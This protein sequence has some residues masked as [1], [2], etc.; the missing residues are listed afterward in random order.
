M[1]KTSLGAPR[2][3]LLRLVRAACADARGALAP[4]AAGVLM[5]LTLLAFGAVEFSRYVAVRSDVQDAVDAAALAV[6]RS[7]SLDATKLQ[8]LG[9]AVIRSQVAFNENL[10]LNSFN[11]SVAGGR[12][13]TLAKVGLSPIVSDMFFANGLTVTGRSEVLRDLWGLELALVLDTTGSMATNNR[14]GIAKTAAEN[15][16]TTLER[17]ASASSNPTAV[18]IGLVPF[19]AAVNVGTQY[20]TAE[21]MDTTALSPAHSRYFRTNRGLPYAGNRFTMLTA[22]GIPWAGCVESRPMPYDVQETAPGPSLPETLFVP[23]FAP[24]DMDYVPNAGTLNPDRRWEG[25]VIQPESY[26]NSYLPDLS[27][28][29][30]EYDRVTGRSGY[31]G[32][33]WPD[34][35]IN[36][37]TDYRTAFLYYSGGAEG[38]VGVHTKYNKPSVDAE[39]TA[40]RFDRASRTKGPN[41]NC[42][43]TPITRITDNGDAV[44]TA[45]K[46][47]S[48]GGSTNIPM[49]LMWGWHLISPRGPFAD[50]KPYGTKG[51]T[52]IIVLMTDGENSLPAI[53]GNNLNGSDYTAVGYAR[54]QR[55]GN[56]GN[57]AAALTT[58]LNNRL[59]IL[60][61]N[62][63]RAGV[64]LYTVR[65]EMTGDNTML[66]ACATDPAKAFDVKNAAALDSTFQAIARS[67]Q[68]LRV[69]R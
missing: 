31:L 20:A 24:D 30:W 55:I 4:M 60:C 64:I 37:A 58:A 34:F 32:Q 8:A 47:M 9:E 19:A 2:D 21:W 43:T 61:T 45:I 56:T 44:I 36:F 63:K 22:M 15:F 59:S 39:V 41:R 10:T 35:Y 12:I 16:V 50:G 54:E 62:V 33:Y 18:K 6:A 5:M 25:Q 1:L 29:I 51:N 40:G 42:N 57:D 23:Y 49:G 26:P 67:V 38:I 68:N 7:S 14:I 69:A 65:L 48:I 3:A 17:A 11:V 27:R 53:G 66:Q 13:T 28:A 52:K 46:A